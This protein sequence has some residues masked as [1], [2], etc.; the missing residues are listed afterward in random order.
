MS[1]VNFDCI[2]S[3]EPNSIDITPAAITASTSTATATTLNPSITH[4][5]SGA[6]SSSQLQL[7]QSSKNSKDAYLEA[8]RILL[9]LLE[10]VLREPTNA[11]YRTIRLEN[12][13]IKEKLLSVA[14]IAQL[15]NAIGFKC[16]A[17]EYTLPK[18][19]PLQRIQ[20]YWNVLQERRESWLKGTL[21][22]AEAV[23]K[24]PEV[25]DN[26]MAA[27]SN[28]NTDQPRKAEPL[29]ALIT[30]SI[31]YQQRIQFPPVL[32]TNNTFLQ[33][34]ELQSDAV[35]QYEDEQLLAAGRA[36]IP[37]DDLTQKASEKLIAFQERIAEGA[38]NEKEPCIRDL[39]VI[40]LCN[41]FKTE[42]FEWVNNIPCRVCGSEESKLVRTQTEGDLRVEV[43][44]CCGQDTKFYRYNDV[45]QLLVTR[46]GRCGEF[47]NC[48]TFFCRCLD[49][50]ARLVSPRFDHVW[51]EVYSES[52]MRWLHVDPSDNVVDSPLMYQHGWKRSIDYIFAY[53]CDEIQDVT[54]R[55]ANNHKQTL[56]ARR[57]CN[58]ND[59]V[60]A[61]L[62][63][64]KKRQSGFSE[65]R[66]KALSQRAIL[67]LLELTVERQPTEGELK[68]RSSGSLAWRQSRGEHTFNNIFVFTPTAEEIGAKQFNMRYSCA[69]DIYERYL[70]VGSADTKII[71]EYKTWQSAQFSSRNIF[72]KVERD[73]KMAYLVREEDAEQGEIVWKFDFSKAG[74]KIK[75]YNLR[76]ERKTFGEGQ[77]EV[78]VIA[79]NGDANIVGASAFQIK[80]VLSGGKGDVAW[81]H[82]QLF[83]QSLNQAESLFDLQIEF[84]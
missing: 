2:R 83:R 69:K 76:F 7:T 30:R 29:R 31:P 73:W 77:I 50:D 57:L 40:E 70:K 49:Y 46:K 41:W 81:Q 64:R 28:K 60:A 61:I 47:A 34:L 78:T 9:V 19:V 11:K 22:T 26:E 37:I 8:A 45:A 75:S 21:Q 72:R 43:S 67:E 52:Q 82:A 66:V 35:M 5:S 56:Q 74:L 3:I 36:L 33:S 63:I 32:H 54:W 20:Q 65:Q 80:A 6:G 39:I 17:T 13:T 53:S 25:N 62:A 27:L 16:S 4:S 42:F 48:F 38:C 71:Q 10:N 68:G 14:G 51:T 23:Q 24:A 84:I 12:K 79:D 1:E 58:E 44:F 15:L 55:Y 59:L 18:E